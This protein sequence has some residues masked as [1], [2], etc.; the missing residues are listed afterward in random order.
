MKLN[1]IMDMKDY[2]QS[3]CYCP[4]EIYSTDGFFY[5][6]FKTDDECKSLGENK[7]FHCVV[8]KDQM[9]VFYKSKENKIADSV[10]YDATKNNME[11][12]AMLINDEVPEDRQLDVFPDNNDKESFEKIMSMADAVMIG[13]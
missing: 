5:Q 4:G 1:E 8:C 13:N 10:R 2:L 9:I 7:K 11:I 3:R 12:A 6:I